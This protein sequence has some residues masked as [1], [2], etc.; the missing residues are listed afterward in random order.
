VGLVLVVLINFSEPIKFALE[1][2]AKLTG[3]WKSLYWLVFKLFIV[4]YAN[5]TFVLI[6]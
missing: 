3:F 5:I 1:A 2:L 4:S 6:L